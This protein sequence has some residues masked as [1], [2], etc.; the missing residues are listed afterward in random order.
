VPVTALGIAIP[1]SSGTASVVATWMPS[2]TA[3]RPPGRA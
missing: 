3:L 2:L 1:S